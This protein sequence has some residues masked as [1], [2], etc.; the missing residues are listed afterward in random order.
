MKANKEVISVL[1]KK[2][3]E[4]NLLKQ[5]IEKKAKQDIEKLT[6]QLKYLKEKYEGQKIEEKLHLISKSISEFETSLR[7]IGNTLCCN[8]CVEEV[9]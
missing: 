4:I 2:A 7:A 5:E 9:K 3:A 6:D 1:D 8:Y